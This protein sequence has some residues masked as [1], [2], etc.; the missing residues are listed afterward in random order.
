MVLH[1]FFLTTWPN[2]PPSKI[3]HKPRNKKCMAQTVWEASKNIAW[4]NVLYI[5][6]KSQE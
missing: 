5:V 3:P 2:S 4:L 6:F 1:L